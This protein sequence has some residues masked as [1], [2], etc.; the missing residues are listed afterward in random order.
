ML[1][2][3]HTE[4]AEATLNYDTLQFNLLYKSVFYNFGYTGDQQL[5]FIPSYYFYGEVYLASH[6]QD[7]FMQNFPFYPCFRAHEPIWMYDFVPGIVPLD[8]TDANDIYN[9]DDEVYSPLAPDN[10]DSD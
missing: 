8:P 10:Y 7:A 2:I 6:I 9:D 5:T 3:L 4:M 1:S